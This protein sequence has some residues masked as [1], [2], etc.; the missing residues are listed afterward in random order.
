[1]T[2]HE[3]VISQNGYHTALRRASSVGLLR[4]VLGI[5]VMTNLEKR[6]PYFRNSY[7]PENL[8]RRRS[9]VCNRLG[10]GQLVLLAGNTSSGAFDYF[11][12]FNDFYYMT[13]I[14]VPHAYFALDT[15]SCTSTLYL[16]GLDAKMERSEGAM[17]SVEDEEVVK[18][19]TG[20]TY[21]K[22]RE[23]LR[24]DLQLHGTA[25]VSTL[26][27]EGAQVCQDVVQHQIHSYADDPLR[28]FTSTAQLLEQVVTQWGIDV[29]TSSLVAD[30]LTSMRSIKDEEEQ[31]WMR[32]AG[33]L[34]AEAVIQAMCSTK[35]GIRESDLAAVA[36]LVFS[37]NG[38]LG[39][40]YRAIV[41]AGE[42][43]WNAHYFRNNKTLLAGE[44][45]LMDFAPDVH[46][47]T[48][49]IGRLWPVNGKYDDLHRELYGYIVEYH[50]V[51]K[52]HI[53]PGLMPA[54]VMENAAEEMKAV[55]DR[56][57]WSDESFKEGAIRTLSFKGHLSH[58]VGMAVHD[59]GDYHDGPLQPGCVF[60]LDPQMWIPSHRLYIRVEDTVCVT[61]DGIENFTE[62]CPLELD[63]VEEMMTSSGVL[64]HCPK[65]EY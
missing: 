20:V 36:S 57:Y 13:G 21:V 49:D 14:E 30:V 46:Y 28:E 10:T 1:M 55:I 62:R 35:A 23:C 52:R 7:S 26:Y 34:T 41:A 11:R 48:S 19:L 60:A 16:P 29:D 59:F 58:M 32:I 22:A 51:L 8:V 25:A 50:K 3:F 18:Q 53:K 37:V 33:N 12:Q 6:A 40:G 43:I 61:E 17:L 54:L 2:F 42:N 31:T 63:D 27:G 9:D 44:H 24:N 56:W 39:P 45:V 5:S 38:A 4:S 15:T 47:Y 64:E 65:L